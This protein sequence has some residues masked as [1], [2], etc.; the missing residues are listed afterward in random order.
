[1]EM[2]K[3]AKEAAVDAGVDVVDMGETAVDNFADATGVSAVDADALIEFGAGAGGIEADP[4]LNF[5]GGEGGQPIGGG[6]GDQTREVP[7]VAS[8]LVTTSM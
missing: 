6:G 3:D 1:M 5:G 2:T 4:L 8:T 7:E